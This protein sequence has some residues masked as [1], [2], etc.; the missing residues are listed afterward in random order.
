MTLTAVSRAVSIVFN[1]RIWNEYG[2]PSQR[3]YDLVY[4]NEWTIDKF[5]ELSRSVCSDLNGD[6]VW[7]EDDLYGMFM[8][9]GFKGS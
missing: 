7:N 5:I 8:G 9:R 1:K 4:D 3:L 2:D 6:T